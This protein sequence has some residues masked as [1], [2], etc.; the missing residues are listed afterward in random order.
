MQARLVTRTT[1]NA[2]LR[3]VLFETSIE[4]LINATVASKFKF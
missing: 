1:E 4:P 3:E 2:W